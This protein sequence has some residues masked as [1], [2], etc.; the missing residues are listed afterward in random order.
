[1][2]RVFIQRQA[3]MAER[4]R[5]Q[6]LDIPNPVGR[7]YSEWRSDV[8]HS[9]WSS[10][11]SKFGPPALPHI[12][13]SPIPGTFGQGFPG[14]IYISTMAYLKNPL[15]TGFNAGGSQKLYSTNSC[16]RTKW[17]T[18]GGAIVSPLCSIATA[19]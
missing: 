16:R 2:H 8:W 6:P 1:M 7:N 14:L 5:R 19:G 12:T 13:V 10:W 3:A 4:C 15:G 9:P 17:R 18:S 11:V